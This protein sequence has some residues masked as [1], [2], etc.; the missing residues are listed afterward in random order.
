MEPIEIKEI[1]DIRVIGFTVTDSLRNV[2]DKGIVR[3]MHTTIKNRMN[4]LEARTADGVYLIQIYSTEEAFTPDVLFEHIVGVEVNAG[5]QLPEDMVERIIP[6][7][8]YA[9]FLHQGPE[10]TIHQTYDAINNWLYTNYKDAWRKL[11]VE[12]WDRRYKGEDA[13]SEIDLFV[14]LQPDR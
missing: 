14:P 12:Y 5:Q 13:E 2:I 11:D 7:G 9:H 1:G 8:R 3:D 6:A 10:S 4:E